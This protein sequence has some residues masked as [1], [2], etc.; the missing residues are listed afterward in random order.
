MT[1]RF[2]AVAAWLLAAAPAWAACQLVQAELPVR[3]VDQRPVGVLTINGTEV[4][5]LIDSGAFFSMLQPSAAAQLGLRLQRLPSHIRLYG[6]T[7]PIEAKLTRVA[8]VGLLGA[9]LPNVEFIVGGNELG[10]GIMGVLGRNFLSVADTEYDLAHG[11]VRLVFPQGDCDKV[12]LA[13]WA[14]D[15]PVIETELYERDDKGIR[16]AVRVNGVKMRALMD[17]GAP[18]TVLQLK[19]ARRAGV[20]EADLQEPGRVGGAG[21]G[22]VR[23]WTTQIAS[24]ELG[25]EK[26]ANNRMDV[27]D[28]DVSDEE[29]LIGL[30]YFLSHRIYVSRLQRKVYATWNGGQVF[31]RGDAVR[32]YDAR[33][34]ARPAE[35]AH[36]DADALARRGEA[37]AARGEH[38]RAL[39]DLDR[40]IA[41][42]PQAEANWL[43]RARLHWTL[44][45]DDDARRDLDEALRLNPGLHEAR[46]LRARL[47]VANGDADGAR[48]DLLALDQAL[49]PSAHLREAMART[50]ARLDML[51]QAMRQWG[52]WEDTHGGD[53]YL[54]DMLNNR[55][56]LRLRL[57]VEL[58]QALEDCKAS[59]RLDRD[60]AASRD[61]LGWV[62]LLLGDPLAAVKAFDA[63]LAIKPLSFS[64][65]GRALARQRLGQIDAMRSDLAAARR[66]N[67]DVDADLRKE[68]LP[69]A[70][71]AP[72]P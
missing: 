41:L 7:G 55:C 44:D 65:Y 6:H 21:L 42:A 49:P 38:E 72:P 2:A 51:P 36:D 63:A 13:H 70:G 66:L 47:Q 54:P 11:V 24:F 12:N 64:H 34:A 28:T 23:S 8:Q 22:R 10:S 15:A 17:T 56:W 18:R 4:P 68:G 48:A 58:P 61:S 39:Q 31:T 33:Y 50:Y 14:G 40:A 37:H 71:D 69:V 19:A 43:A 5:M 52:L 45:R 27:D 26:V 35:V 46:S 32:A 25:G 20:K 57:N 62:Q 16:L 53:A 9:N 60:S 1:W 29:M 30:D 67:P 3:T 59:V